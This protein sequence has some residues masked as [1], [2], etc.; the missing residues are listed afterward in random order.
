MSDE[1]ADAIEELEPTSEQTVIEVADG[2]VT[3]EEVVAEEPVEEK[4]LS[5]DELFEMALKGEE[6]GDTEQE[7]TEVVEEVEVEP[8]VEETP[9]PEYTKLVEGE[10]DLSNQEE[11]DAINY[12]AGGPKADWTKHP[13]RMTDEQKAV[14]KKHQS[15]HDKSMLQP[16]EE[17]RKPQYSNDEMQQAVQDL[18]KLIKGDPETKNKYSEVNPVEKE[19]PKVDDKEKLR[20][21]VDSLDCGDREAVVATFSE[22]LNDV[23]TQ[24]VLDAEAK[25]KEAASQHVNESRQ[26]DEYESWINKVT[27]DNARLVERDG[28]AYTQYRDQI[29]RTLELTE[30]GIPN[31]ITGTLIRDVEEAYA[32][33]LKM[34]SGGE[35]R[36]ASVRPSPVVAPPAGSA[37]GNGTDST[38][39]DYDDPDFMSK[40]WD[41]SIKQK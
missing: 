30:K 27:E 26:K 36:V 6:D 33:A 10:I 9:L 29:L 4:E 19:S 13:E 1:I 16:R 24:A 34:D 7:S 32:L 39:L 17:T 41:R 40:A 15:A 31:P 37:S 8:E 5:L 38:K 3:T 28:S 12:W 11:V 2:E 21:F 18:A 14:F 20:K 23:R 22:I 25:A 35:Q